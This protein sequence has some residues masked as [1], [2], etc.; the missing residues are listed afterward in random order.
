MFLKQFLGSTFVCGFQDTEP[1]IIKFET[2]CHNYSIS[3]SPQRLHPHFSFVITTLPKFFNGF[4][5]Y[6]YNNFYTG[7]TYKLRAKIAE[8][9]SL[10]IIQSAQEDSFYTVYLAEIERNKRYIE[11]IIGIDYK[12]ENTQDNLIKEEIDS[13]PIIQDQNE[14]PKH[15]IENN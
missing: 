5:N 12:I 11:S 10:K 2:L 13:N 14:S 9:R 3:D 6:Y 1:E 7:T 8:H 4:Y 15:F